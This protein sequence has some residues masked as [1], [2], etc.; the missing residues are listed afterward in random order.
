MEI[1]SFYTAFSAVLYDGID[2]ESMGSTIWPLLR[3]LQSFVLDDDTQQQ[4]HRHFMYWL[5][6]VGFVV[7]GLCYTHMYNIPLF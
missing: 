1:H 6:R 4:H 7:L 2:S 5:R 3:Q